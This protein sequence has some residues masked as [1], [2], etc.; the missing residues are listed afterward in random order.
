MRNIKLLALSTLVI[1]ISSCAV[2]SVKYAAYTQSKQ[3][4]DLSTYTDSYMLAKTQLT[5]NV[6]Q[7]S[8][9]KPVPSQQ[10]VAGNKKEE[11]QDED[12]SLEMDPAYS[13]TVA[14]RSIDDPTQAFAITPWNRWYGV[15]TR[16]SLEKFE[17]TQIIK[18]AK[19]S[20]E[21]KRIEY[22]TAI[23]KVL[24][25]VAKLA[26]T[27]GA[28][29]A[30]PKFVVDTLSNMRAQSCERKACSVSLITSASPGFDALMNISEVP[31]D[32]ISTIEA[33]DD[34]NLKKA[35]GVLFASTCRQA[36]LVVRNISDPTQPDMIRHISVADPRYV[37][38]IGLPDKGQI[39][40]HSECGYSVLPADVEMQSDF[41]VA[42]KYVSELDKFRKLVRQLRDNDKAD[43]VQE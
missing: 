17:N 26:I 23:F 31:P 28:P 9:Q 11:S 13:V 1:A 21:D 12:S 2:P 35:S 8:M 29:G 43:D 25:T 19:I 36:T 22:A 16:V 40:A 39:V 10:S 34:E 7:E 32:A 14:L 41:D 27:P 37:Q 30:P 15:K 33:I 5:F 6:T 18:S 20:V 42:E 3:R 4:Q 38:V 24:G